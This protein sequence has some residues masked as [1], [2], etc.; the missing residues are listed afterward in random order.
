MMHPSR[1]VV[2]RSRQAASGRQEEAASSCSQ[3]VASAKCSHAAFSTRRAEIKRTLAYSYTVCP[4]LTSVSQR[5]TSC[6]GESVEQ[7]LPKGSEPDG[8]RLRTGRT[9]GAGLHDYQKYDERFRKIS[10]FHLR[11]VPL[12]LVGLL[13]CSS[14]SPRLCGPTRPSQCIACRGLHSLRNTHAFLPPLHLASRGAARHL[15]NL[16]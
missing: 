1:S 12:L 14:L 4:D 8:R 15:S 7:A 2:A 11:K 6:V 9:G 5:G 10:T 13:P 16:P 3:E